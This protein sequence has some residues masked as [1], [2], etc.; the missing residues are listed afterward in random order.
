[1]GYK[2]DACNFMTTSKYNYNKHLQTKKH[3]EYVTNSQHKFNIYKFTCDFCNNSFAHSSGLSRHKNICDAKVCMENQIG[4][5][6][7]ELGH[8][9]ELLRKAEETIDILK[10]DV[11]HLKHIV[12]NSGSIVKTSVSTVAYVIKHF[13]E[14]PILEPLK[15]FTAICNNQCNQD[16]VETL[17]YEFNNGHL[18]VYI[19]DFIIKLYKKDDPTKQSLWNSDT[20]R[21][22]YLIRE[23][24]NNKSDWRID[25][26]GIRTDNYIISPLLSHIDEQIRSYVENFDCDYES[27][28]TK[29]TEKKMLKLKSSIEILKIIE[30]KTLN[31][32]IL[33]Y[34]APY[35][36]LNKHIVSP[37]TIA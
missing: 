19:G 3:N 25:K 6:N 11:R 10:S 8:K 9:D 17:I 34:M 15:D 1:M 14:T 30:N 31:D 20:N 7:M 32:D 37:P 5:L 24:L 36:Y 35:F 12:D 21:L 27:C 4:R 13:Q 18:H 22:T 28:S 23:I 33:K 16:F 26:K 29:E 2:C